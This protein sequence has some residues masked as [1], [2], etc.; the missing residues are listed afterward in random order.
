[1]LVRDRRSD[2]DQHDTANEFGTP[3]SDGTEH[4]AQ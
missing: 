4:S 1:M 2:A 3:A